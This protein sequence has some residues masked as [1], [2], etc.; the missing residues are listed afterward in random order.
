VHHPFGSDSVPAIIARLKMHKVLYIAPNK[1][2][3]EERCHAW[4]KQFALLTMN[5]KEVP[6]FNSSI[7]CMALTTTKIMMKQRTYLQKFKMPISSSLHQK[8]GTV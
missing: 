2:L 8:N 3:C 4:T 5:E 7:S 6:G 1:A